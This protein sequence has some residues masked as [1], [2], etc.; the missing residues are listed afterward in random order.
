LVLV[1]LLGGCIIE[2]PIPPIV[3]PEPGPGPG[4]K[5]GGVVIVDAGQ[6]P[7]PPFPGSGRNGDQG[8]GVLWLVRTDRGTAN[9]APAYAAAIRAMNQQLTAEGFT[10]RVTAVASLYE[11]RLYWATYGDYW[12]NYGEN[13]TKELQSFLESAANS[14]DGA[15]PSICST[16][17]MAELG[18]RLSTT[19]LMPPG[20][21]APSSHAPFGSSLGALLV[22]VLDH[23]SRS[24]SYHTASCTPSGTSPADWFGGMRDPAT[25]L[26]RADYGWSLPRSQTR[27]LFVTTSE[28][29][30]YEQMRSRCAAMTNFPRPALDAINPASVSFYTDF[31]FNLGNHQSGLGTQ[32]DLCNALGGDWTS[33]TRTFA[34]DWVNLL[35]L[36]AEQ[37]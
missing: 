18:S 6:P 32:V 24:V 4:P 21:T 15:A 36:P 10:V 20:A 31:A 8:T 2:P 37:R 14:V 33:Y 16:T 28:T 5:D 7:P 25:W 11:S 27:F 35:R 34:R 19:G 13:Q 1:V 26:N 29:E 22:G 17:A 3:I 9:L 12:T 23:G 30:S